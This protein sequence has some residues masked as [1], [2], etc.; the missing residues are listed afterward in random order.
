MKDKVIIKEEKLFKSFKDLWSVPYSCFYKGEWWAV[1]SFSTMTYAWDPA[2]G[3]RKIIGENKID[4]N[5]IDGSSHQVTCLFERKGELYI[6]SSKGFFY[7]MTS[8]KWQ[9]HSKEEM[10][11]GSNG[12]LFQTTAYD[13]I[14]DTLLAYGGQMQGA[15][16]YTV[17]KDSYLY[18]FKTDTWSI[19][20]DKELMK[21]DYEWIKKNKE[22][23]EFRV[24]Y[25]QHEKKFLLVGRNVSSY[26]D[27]RS[28]ESF[29]HDP[30]KHGGGC[31]LTN[32]KSEV[33]L[34][35]NFYLKTT[36]IKG[37]TIHKIQDRKV[38]LVSTIELPEGCRPNYD[39]RD[40][41]FDA[42]TGCLFIQTDE[43][44]I[45]LDLKSYF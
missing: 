2:K 11:K 18:N 45:S 28:W 20:K 13:P 21:V 7:E 1:A 30:I 31:L 34:Y 40:C 9:V 19:V 10:K 16:R 24:A 42:S 37:V 5:L 41:C 27:G 35:I 33:V 3:M 22:N 39:G 29:S 8:D 38:E 36:S 17:V 6:M 32:G 15:A 4:K 26:F 44:N 43:M 25:H 23:V 12:I 14:N